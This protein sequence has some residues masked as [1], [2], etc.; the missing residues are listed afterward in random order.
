MMQSGQSRYGVGH[1]LAVPGLR[2]DG[3]QVS[4]E[5]TLMALKGADGRVTGLVAIMRDITVRF[6]ETKALRA[7]LR[8]ALAGAAAPQA[9]RPG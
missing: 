7:R 5:F 2:K 4:L 9:D 3:S 6:E 8:E 1:L